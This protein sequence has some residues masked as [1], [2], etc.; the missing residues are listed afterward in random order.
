MVFTHML[1]SHRLIRFLRSTSNTTDPWSTFDGVDYV[2]YEH[3]PLILFDYNSHND[4][5]DGECD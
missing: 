1:L 3:I 5:S 2:E 4:D